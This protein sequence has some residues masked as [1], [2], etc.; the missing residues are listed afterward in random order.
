MHFNVMRLF[1]ISGR[2]MAGSVEEVY[3][4][5]LKREFFPGWLW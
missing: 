2:V 3:L 1:L 4:L 5:L